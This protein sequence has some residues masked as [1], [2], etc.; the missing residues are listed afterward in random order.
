[1]SAKHEH[2]DVIRKP[3]ITEKATFDSSESNRFTFEIDRRATKAQVT[4]R[5]LRISGGNLQLA[6]ADL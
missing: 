3:I 1:M 4:A 6:G 2:Y 5:V